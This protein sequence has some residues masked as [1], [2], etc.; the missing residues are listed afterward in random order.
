[1]HTVHSNCEIEAAPGHQQ[2]EP[3]LRSQ[4]IVIYRYP[5]SPSKQPDLELKRA[6]KDLVQEWV[7]DTRNKIQAEIDELVKAE[8]QFCLSFVSITT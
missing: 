4:S 7:H 2:V 6:I 3:A 1:M 8:Q 5:S